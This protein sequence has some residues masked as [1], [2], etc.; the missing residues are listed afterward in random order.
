MLSAMASRNYGQY[1]GLVRALELVGE[2]WA[3]LVVR[4]L[5]PGPK[6]FTDLRRG[7]PRIPTNI[8]SARLKEMEQSGIVRRRVLP[9]PSSSVV[10]ELTEYGRELEDIV[11]PLL[12]WGSK[13]LGEPRPDDTVHAS[14]LMLGLRVN[15]RPEAARGLSA[16]FELHVKDAVIHARLQDGALELGEGP[17]TDP[18]LT[19]ETDFRLKALLTG[20]LTPTEA[21]ESGAVRTTGDAALLDRFPELFPLP[22]AEPLA[23]G[24]GAVVSPPA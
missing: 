3:L 23:A 14:S 2:R 18:D 24:P 13:S 17:A 5:I 15:F 22:R 19:I 12:R 20:E 6:R 21:R 4:D 8:L 10:Y 1:C 9:R 16:T 7:L 11:V